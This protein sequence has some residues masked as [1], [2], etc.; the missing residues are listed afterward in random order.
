MYVCMYVCMA[1]SLRRRGPRRARRQRLCKAA[2][3]MLGV[4]VGE[5][6]RERGP[7]LSFRGQTDPIGL[8]FLCSYKASQGIFPLHP[9]PPQGSDFMCCVAHIPRPIRISPFCYSSGPCSARQSHDMPCPC[10]FSVCMCRH[11]ISSMCI[12]CFFLCTSRRLYD[13]L[14]PYFPC[15]PSEVTH[16]A[17]HAILRLLKK[18]QLVG[19]RRPCMR[20]VQD[21]VADCTVEEV[22]SP[23]QRDLAVQQ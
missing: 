21:T 5:V 23:I 12:A 11:P 6:C 16:T 4:V 13:P 18:P 9:S 7:L 19:P 1:V 8:M 2:C 15:A 14:V 3:S 22:Q 10:P 20:A 17:K